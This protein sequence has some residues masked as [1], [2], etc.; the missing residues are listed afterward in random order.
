MKRLGIPPTLYSSESNLFTPDTWSNSLPNRPFH[1]AT[2]AVTIE[3]PSTLA[4]LR[5]RA[6]GREEVPTERIYGPLGLLKL[7]YDP[8][9]SHVDHGEGG[10][11]PPTQGVG[12][13]TAKSHHIN[14]AA[15]VECDILTAP[16]D[17]FSL[18]S[19]W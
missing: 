15:R 1:T 6:D 12:I 2:E 19:I 7:P 8:P 3:S 18:S 9:R 13:C 17:S 16:G 11:M 5:A 10:N 14:I 4:Q